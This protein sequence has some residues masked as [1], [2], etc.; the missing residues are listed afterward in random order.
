MATEVPDNTSLKS[1]HDFFE[2]K[3]NQQAAEIAQLKKDAKQ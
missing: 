2:Q 3:F 1:L